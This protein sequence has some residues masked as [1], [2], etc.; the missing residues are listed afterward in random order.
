MRR[1]LPLLLALAACGPSL[2]AGDDHAHGDLEGPPEDLYA[3]LPQGLV[4]C[5]ERQDTGYTSGSPFAITVVTCDSKP[6]ERDTANAYAVMQAAAKAAGVNLVVV[7]GF[8]T[9]SEQQYLYNCY[10]NCSCN[11]CNLAA[12]PGY[13]NHQ[14]GH[15]LDLNTSS[16]GVLSWLNTHGASFGFKRTVPSEPWHWEWWG[17]GPGG[18][19]CGLT[20]D[21]CTTGE[22]SA[23]ANYGCGC[24]NHACKGGFCPGTGC[25]Q[26][27]TNDCGGVGCSCANSECSG[28]F[29]PGSG[30]TQK[31]TNDCAAFGCGCVDHACKGGACEG[32]GCTAKETQDC[33]A[34]GCGCVDHACNGGACEGSGCTAK[35]AN[36]CADAGLACA[37]A[38]CQPG[39]ELPPP[40]DAG[41]PWPTD[42]GTEVTDAGP[43]LTVPAPPGTEPV[44]GVLGCTH[45]PATA[46]APLLLLALLARRRVR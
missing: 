35:Q 19:P 28:G 8:R 1:L 36:D 17:G 11:N 38:Q 43:P 6:C 33:A 29:C 18:G 10:V 23:C 34:F 16:P 3:S 42:A 40:S 7:S 31:E 44:L 22:A 37:N 4:T 27:E 26:K 45:A 2:E 12:K 14:S 24:V 32:S 20:P 13:S 25:T 21:N 39:S 9:Q 5:N 30:C 15:A 41:E 46:L